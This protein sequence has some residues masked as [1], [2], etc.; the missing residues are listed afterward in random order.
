MPCVCQIL[1]IKRKA[2]A[3][4]FSYAATRLWPGGAFEPTG[5]AKDP[6]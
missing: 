3:A 5:D 6:R 1:E 4:I 2:W